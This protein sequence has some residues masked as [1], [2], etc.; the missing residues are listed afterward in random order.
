[1]NF[2]IV[3]AYNV[4]SPH[5]QI[6]YP[7]DN[8]YQHAFGRRLRSMN[9]KA[10]YLSMEKARF[11]K[12]KKCAE[13]IAA[14]YKESHGSDGFVFTVET[15]T[16]QEA[17]ITKDRIPLTADQYIPNLITAFRIKRRTYC[18]QCGT[19]IPKGTCGFKIRTRYVHLVICSTCIKAAGDKADHFLEQNEDGDEE[20]KKQLEISRLSNML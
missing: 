13:K 16:S 8:F 4:R 19:L 14:K 12:S 7:K 1:M 3:K 5:K 15:I 11:Y 10:N 20:L 6:Y 17:N 2:Y 18:K 9:Y